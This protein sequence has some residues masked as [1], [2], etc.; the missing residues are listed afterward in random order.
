MYRNAFANVSR[1]IGSL[2]FAGSGTASEIE[3]PMPG[4][5]PKVIIGSNALASIVNSRS[6]VALRRRLAAC[7]S[8]HR[9]VP[10]R[11]LRCERPSSNVLGRLYRGNT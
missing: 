9:R 3:I 7:A 6:Y 4:F 8:A 1:S 10:F 2:T 11:A 5:V